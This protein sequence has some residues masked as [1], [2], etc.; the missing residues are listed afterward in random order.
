[1]K[2]KTIIAVVVLVIILAGACFGTKL[3]RDKQVEDM[4]NEAISELKS[5]T[6]LADYRD[7][8]KKEVE[9][10]LNTYA[11]KISDNKDQ[12]EIAAMIDQAKEEISAIKTDAQL[13]EEE[14]I[15][16]KKAAEEAAAKKAA[17]EAAAKK[18]AEEAAAKKA[19]EEAAKKAAEEAAAKKAAEE[20]AAKKAAEE[21]KS[22][23]GS[24]S[25]GCVGND[26]KYFY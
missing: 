22:S 6:D 17:E 3:Y 1:M 4:R 16:A 7:S 8:E 2:K 11:E 9:N 10:I 26:A 12:Q 20:A 18:A 24:N 5:G 23:N 19:A 25:E 14:E 13:T 15:A 21:E